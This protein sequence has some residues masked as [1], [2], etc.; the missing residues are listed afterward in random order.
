VPPSDR[1]LDAPGSL[2]GFT[3]KSKVTDLIR[4]LIV[5]DSAFVRRAIERMLSESTMIRIVGTA[6]NGEEAI[7]LACDRRPDVIVMD[8]NM[9][10]IDGLQALESIMKRCPCPVLMMSTL[11]RAG[12]T[13][14]I[15][16]LELGAVDFIDKSQAGTAMDIYRLGPQLRDKVLTVARADV[17]PA[18]VEVPPRKEKPQPRSEAQPR[19]AVSYD[20]IAIGASTGGPRALNEILPHLPG[21]LGVGLVI[22]QHMPP[23]FTA[24]LA[25]RLDERCAL[26]VRE[27]ADGDPIESGAA[28]IAPGG[29]QMQLERRGGRLSVRIQE[30]PP[31][32]LHRPSVDVLFESVAETL[33]PRAIG[34]VLT[35]M[36]NDGA[37]GLQAMR[38]AG[39]R[40]VA[41]SS[42]TAVIFGMPRAAA[43]A[44]E[45]VQPLHRIAPTLIELCGAS[46]PHAARS[47]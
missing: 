42:E 3:Q 40:T 30:S 20:L 38:D 22:A 7:R 36:G 12:A 24:T 18:P 9:P 43:V 8:V 17:A 33:G 13:I 37:T 39:A 23:G 45:M 29:K 47:D 6:T 35:G 16:A 15:R 26:H 31:D 1:R 4:V 34:V 10:E 41:E 27:A 2:P 19:R 32:R 5:D 44:A 25:E 21:N 28:L 46:D 11:T 14:T